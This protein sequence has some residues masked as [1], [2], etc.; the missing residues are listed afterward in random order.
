[1]KIGDLASTWVTVHV[2]SKIA[3][4][5][6]V[7]PLHTL[8]EKEQTF[9]L[10]LVDMGVQFGCFANDNPFLVKVILP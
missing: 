1:M 5:I 2:F 10:L 7:G 6:E 8:G 3:R 4:L 9:N